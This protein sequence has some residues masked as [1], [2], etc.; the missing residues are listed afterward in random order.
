MS[1]DKDTPQ[2]ILDAA[3]QLF[4]E[5]GFAAVSLRSIV[6]SAG[7]NI[8]LVNYHFGSRDELVCE[9]IRRRVVRM[10]KKRFQ[11][12]DEAKRSFSD[13]PIPVR[14]ILYAF[15]APAV[16]LGQDK[17]SGG[18]AFFRIIARAHAETAPHIQQVLFDELK[19]VIAVFLKEFEKSLPHLS[20]V[21]RGFRTAFMA[22][23]MFQAVLLPL[24]PKFIERFSEG[25]GGFDQSNMLEMLIDFC[26]G[27]LSFAGSCDE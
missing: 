27:G 5:H 12:L 25:S 16:E 22:G 1:S 2:K 8:A 19:E 24:K 3:E 17:K 15:L 13:T 9:V 11:L 26:E 10:N 7:V 21:E 23:A 4:A 18:Q 20:D 6:K 14:E